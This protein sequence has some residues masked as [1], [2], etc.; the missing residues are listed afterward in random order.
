MQGVQKMQNLQGKV[1]LIT[2]GGS[3]I[4][5]AAAKLFAEQGAQCVIIGRRADVLE[6]AAKEVGNGAVSIP[7]DVTRLEDHERVAR[8]VEKRF[9]GVD[10]YFANAGIINIKPSDQVSEQE[11][12][13]HFATNAKGIFFGV[14]TTAKVMR[15]GGSIIVTGS[16]ASTKVLHNHTLYAGTKAAISAFAR[17]FALEL[18]G[19]RIRVN[20]LSPGPVETEVLDKLGLDGD[21]KM[22]LLKSMEELVPAGRIGFP[23]E[24]AQAAL[25]L[26]S[27][28]SSF[29]NGVELHADGGM[30]LV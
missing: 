17:Y 4:G 14:Q 25:F 20:V 28:A 11:F 21:A 18:K 13:A 30:A 29:V 9:G 10:I 24:L 22:N 8:D 27:E 3:G 19:R 16:L 2:G 5:K 12:D 7:A 26:A 1:A 23:Q 6:D 15:D